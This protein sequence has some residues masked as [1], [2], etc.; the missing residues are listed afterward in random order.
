MRRPS[1]SPRTTSWSRIRGRRSSGPT[2]WPILPGRRTRTSSPTSARTARAT[3]SPRPRAP[4]CSSSTGSA[5]DPAMLTIEPPIYQVRGVTIFRDH[6]DPDQFYFLPPVPRLAPQGDGVAFALF[7]YRRDLT[8]NPELDPTR[9]KGGGL[10]LFEVETPVPS[11]AAIQAELSSLAQRA[12]ARLSPVLFRS[13][14][15]QAI[16]AHAE[17]D[18]FVQDLVNA[19]AAP[20]TY[21]HHAAF[22]LALSAEG[23]TLVEAAARGGQLPV[24]VA[25]EFRFPALTP[26]L[27]ARAHMDYDRI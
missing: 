10:A 26:S 16:V 15:V 13:G 3:S 25:Y 23:A 21:P 12:D 5:E 2:P 19:R 8:D 27:H 6:E 4:T 7:K 22:A 9:A 18:R 11:A 20:L 17:G 24:G 1:S 14:T